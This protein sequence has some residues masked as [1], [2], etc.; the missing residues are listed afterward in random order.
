MTEIEYKGCRGCRTLTTGCL[1][2]RYNSTGLCPCVPC[3]IKPMC[4]NGC[5]AYDTFREGKEIKPDDYEIWD[6]KK[7]T[8]K[9]L[10]RYYFNDYK[11]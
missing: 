7:D 1:Y 3:V 10:E 2:K 11:L 5:P 9:I 4:R 8:A 6:G